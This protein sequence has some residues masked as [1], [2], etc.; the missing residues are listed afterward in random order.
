MAAA[1][2]THEPED[3]SLSISPGNSLTHPDFSLGSFASGVS[4]P[5]RSNVLRPPRTSLAP[6]NG[7]ST[8]GASPLGPRR[9]KNVG[10]YASLLDETDEGVDLNAS[11][12]A[13]MP[14]TPGPATGMKGILGR[15]RSGTVTGGSTA[16][17]TNTN[18]ASSTTNKVSKLTLREQEKVRYAC[19]PRCMPLTVFVSST[20]TA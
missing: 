4:T 11:V 18:G 17:M 8:N 16:S 7:G 9:T 13:D 3:L 15:T 14:D 12:G 2:N 10:D 19:R 20:S 1:L 6:P 5:H